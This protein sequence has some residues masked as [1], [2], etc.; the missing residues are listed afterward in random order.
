MTGCEKVL[1]RLKQGPATHHELYQLGVIAHS[2]VADLRRKGYVIECEKDGEHYI[3]KLA[4]AFSLLSAPGSRSGETPLA[5]GM[6]AG[7]PH[8]FTLGLLPP[9]QPLGCP[10]WAATGQG[11]LFEVGA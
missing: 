4:G 8:S 2:R 10:A 6:D 11:S 3:Y 7:S 9:A 5:A 1:A